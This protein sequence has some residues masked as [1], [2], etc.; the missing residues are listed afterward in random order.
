M[1]IFKRPELEYELFFS[2]ERNWPIPFSIPKNDTNWDYKI[3]SYT[4]GL[5]TKYVH[6][7]QQRNRATKGSHYKVTLTYTLSL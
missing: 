7:L 5:Y 2:V 3:F 1:K 4:C 6:R